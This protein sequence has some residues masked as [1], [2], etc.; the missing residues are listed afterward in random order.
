MRA[1]QLRSDLDWP[2][3]VTLPE[4]TPGPGEVLLRVRAAGVCR[5]DLHM[6]HNFRHELVRPLVLGHEI[7]GE[8]VGGHGDFHDL[9]P[10][11]L[12]VV[13]HKLVCGK[14]RQ[15][16]RGRETLCQNSVVL[17][18]DRAGGFAE[19]VTTQASR[20]LPLPPSV[21]PA[22]GAALTCGGVTAYHALRAAANVAKSDTVVVLGTGG[23]GLF[24]VQIARILGARVVAADLRPEALRRATTLGAQR[25]VRVDPKHPERLPEELGPDCADVVLDLV[26]D[27]AL[28]SGLMSILAPGGRYVVTSGRPVDWVPV[29]PYPVFRRELSIVGS[30]GSSFTELEQVLKLAAM[31]RLVSSVSLEAPLSDG[32][33]V[34]RRVDA[35]EVV[36]R[37]ILVP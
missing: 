17:G 27:S 28:A 37:T 18:I 3:L 34:L 30:R 25:S 11:Q 15:C 5:T 20:V 8:V 31:G 23:V 16:A 1:L 29:A 4:P 6:I 10:G 7:A 2:K 35:G 22:A 21:S 19:Y 13:H 24:A 9:S 33:E 32:E 14:C 36:G 12:V 26:G